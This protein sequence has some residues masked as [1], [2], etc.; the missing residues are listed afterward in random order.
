MQYFTFLQP[1]RRGEGGGER[2]GGPLWS[3]VVPQMALHPPSP[4]FQRIPFVGA[5]VVE[6]G[7]VGLYGRPPSPQWLNILSQFTIYQ[8]SNFESPCFQT[9]G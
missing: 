2:L 8:S 7:W 5:R 9:W 6:S 1:F 4:T 3:P